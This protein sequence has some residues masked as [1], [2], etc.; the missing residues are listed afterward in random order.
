VDTTTNRIIWAALCLAQLTYVAVVFQIEPTENPPDVSSTMLPALVVL[1]LTIATGTIWWRKHALVGP[2]RSGKLDLS[3]LEGQAHSFAPFILN[4]M[5]SEAVAIFGLVLT[6][7][8]SEGSYVLGFVAASLG[9]MFIH[10]PFALDI[11]SP[12]RDSNSVRRPPPIA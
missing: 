8:S 1:G 3:T 4:L 5:L 10:R 12:Q 2:I 9:L 7:R 11:Q 6:I